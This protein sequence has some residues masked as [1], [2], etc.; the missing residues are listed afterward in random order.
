MV[1]FKTAGEFRAWLEAN[2]S[3][4][5]EIVILLHR[6]DSGKGG[7]TYPEALDEALCFG[8]IDGI[9][10]KASNGSYSVR[11]TPRKKRSIW[12]LVNVRHVERLSAS[13]RMRPP[14]LA[15]FLARDPSRTGV[16]SFERRTDRFPRDIE[17]VFRKDAVAWKNW[18]R[19]PAGYRR[20]TAWWVASAV[21][22][23]TRM[24]RLAA[25]VR[26]SASGLRLPQFS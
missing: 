22:E 1:H 19:E 24:R 7:L 20:T 25:L 10:G 6:K 4:H 21:R 8:W 26:A 11:F 2:H 5:P 23:E 3:K 18:S 17:R 13:G 15:A 12:S 9:R 16:Y 14:G